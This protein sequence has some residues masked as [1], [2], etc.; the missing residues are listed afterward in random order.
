MKLRNIFLVATLVV[1]SLFAGQALHV[2][3]EA[4]TEYVALDSPS[5]M[6]LVGHRINEGVIL[7]L[8]DLHDDEGPAMKFRIAIHGSQANGEQISRGEGDA[9][10]FIPGYLIGE[11]TVIVVF[12][13]NRYVHFDADGNEVENPVWPRCQAAIQA[14]Q[15]VP[16]EPEVTVSTKDHHLGNPSIY[17]LSAKIDNVG[18]LPVSDLTLRYY[19]TVE[20]ASQVPSVSDYYTPNST[21]KLLQVPGTKEYALE[22]DYVGLTLEAGESSEGAVSNQIHVSYPGY[23]A[24]DKQND[25]SNPIPTEI[26]HLPSS[27]F[28]MP[29]HKV[30]VYDANGTL[31]SGMEHPTYTYDQFVDVQ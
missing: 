15:N 1:T 29:N 24:I 16:E 31:I 7:Y 21:V 28:Y 20:E 3:K 2:N 12:D 30:S 18:T 6:G 17:V 22:L 25:F 23:A 10:F 14:I 4:V 26:A 9:V 13:D 19:I 27:T 11:H 5:A 8:T